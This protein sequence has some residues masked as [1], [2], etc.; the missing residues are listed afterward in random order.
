MIVNQI[1]FILS[2]LGLKYCWADDFCL[3]DVEEGIFFG[4]VKTQWIHG[5]IRRPPTFRTIG[6]RP[7]LPNLI[8]YLARAS[9][10]TIAYSCLQLDFKHEH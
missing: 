3:P 10:V 8:T 1:Q 7:I 9:N 4:C 6:W 5:Y 2:R